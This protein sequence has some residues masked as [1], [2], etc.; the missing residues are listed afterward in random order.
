VPWLRRLVAGLPPRRSGFDPGLV[1]VGFV[2]EHVFPLPI[3]FHRCSINWKAK[4]LIIFITGL[5]NKPQGYGASVASAAGPLSTHKKKPSRRP[6]FKTQFL[7]IGSVRKTYFVNL[8]AIPVMAT[9]TMIPDNP[10]C[11]LNELGTE[12]VPWGSRQL[13]VS[14]FS[15]QG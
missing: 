12:V 3:S 5:H 10:K 14:A 6:T 11:F 13:H 15:R 1:H 9:N 2:V 7:I 4:K 8:S